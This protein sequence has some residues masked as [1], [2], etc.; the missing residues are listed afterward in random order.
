[1]NK[2]SVSKVNRP[3]KQK[4]IFQPRSGNEMFC[5][6]RKT[7]QGEHVCGK[8]QVKSDLNRI[9]LISKEQRIK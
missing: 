2:D 5:N 1:M 7:E 8:K 9:S 6:S 3:E 4:L